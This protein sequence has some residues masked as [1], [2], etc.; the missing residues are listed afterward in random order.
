[1]ERDRLCSVCKSISFEK[2]DE[3]RDGL[4]HHQSLSHLEESAQNC[5]LCFLFLE[6]I[7]EKRV[8][9][10][11]PKHSW[12]SPYHVPITLSLERDAQS[13]TLVVSWL[14]QNEDKRSSTIFDL[15]ADRGKL[16]YLP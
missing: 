1:M 10:F 5:L 16:D 11:I 15:S 14:D 3:T 6:A 4:T 9:K 8:R 12:H 7:K 2:I 13:V